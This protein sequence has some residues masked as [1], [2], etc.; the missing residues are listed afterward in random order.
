MENVIF[1]HWINWLVKTT[2]SLK[3]KTVVGVPVLQYF[4]LVAIFI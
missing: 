4:T 1:L 2:G 3:G